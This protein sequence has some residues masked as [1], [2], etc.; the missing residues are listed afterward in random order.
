MPDYRKKKHNKIFSSPKP[1]KQKTVKTTQNEDIK[2]SPAE[3]YR[4]TTV[5]T[6]MKVVRGKKLEQK[7]KLKVLASICLIAVVV[8]GF[9]QFMLPMGVFEGV[10]NLTALI[11][12]G[13]Y[14]LE[15]DGTQTVNAVNRGSYYYVLSNT[16]INAFSS[17]GKKLFSYAHGFERPIIKTS[18]SRAIVFEQNGTKAFIFTLNGLKST[19]ETEQ[20]IITANVSDSGAYAIACRSDKYASAVTVYNK[21]GKMLYEWYSAENT[22]NNVVISPNAKKIA[23]SS[24][25]AENGQYKSVLNVLNFKS[26]TPVYTESIDNALIYDIDSTHKSIFTVVTEN[27][28]KF[29]KWSDFDKKE[30]NNEYAI[31]LF[32][33][34][35]SGFIAVFNRK[36]DKT[37]NRLVVFSKTGK[38]KSELEYNGIISDITVSGNNIYCL[39]ETELHLLGTEG[40]ILRESS[41]GFGAVRISV[42][43]TNTVAVISDNK[44]EKI[45]LEQE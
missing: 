40:E 44:I 36:N 12:A 20:S 28:L 45:K 24:F 38:L 10:S 29:I 34:E 17:S 23:V 31:T 16:H 27:S 43:S 32:R 42:T 13:N 18:A 15:L 25:K 33:P 19:V 3:K 8:L 2:M 41:S 11:G 1:K 37:D 7:R 35:K 39:G 30:Y 14:P 4:K 6:N 21:H 5:N 22:V 26:A 9:F